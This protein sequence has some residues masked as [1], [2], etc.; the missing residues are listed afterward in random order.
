LTR[1][2]RTIALLVLIIG[3]VQIA[4]CAAD[5]DCFL[6]STAGISS[7]SSSPGDAD[8]CLCCAQNAQLSNL[9]DVPK[10]AYVLFVPSKFLLQ[11]PQDRTL[12]I[13][14]PPRS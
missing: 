1:L 5:C 3:T 4:M 6:P 8:G 7:H 12:L 10:L 11:I 9:I 13:D 2:L 14:L